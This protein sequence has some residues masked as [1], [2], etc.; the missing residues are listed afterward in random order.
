MQSQC[1]RLERTERCADGE[2]GRDGVAPQWQEAGR[3]LLIQALEP[4]SKVFL[5]GS[6]EGGWRLCGSGCSRGAGRCREG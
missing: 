3:W 5:E 1:S 6:V 2:N 4:V